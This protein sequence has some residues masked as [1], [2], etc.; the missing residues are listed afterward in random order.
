MEGVR[1]KLQDLHAEFLQLLG[2]DANRVGGVEFV[3]SV[4]RRSLAL[5][6]AYR[7][8]RPH[9]VLRAIGACLDAVE[10]VHVEGIHGDLEVL[11][12]LSCG[13]HSPVL[14][15][16]GGY[17]LPRLEAP[18]L[19]GKVWARILHVPWRHVHQVLLPNAVLQAHLW[20]HDFS[21]PRML[22]QRM[23]AQ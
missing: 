11:G 19:L 7:G 14:A 9:V 17:I 12:D 21:K 5:A 15:E 18:T 6:L 16:D 3:A 1:L 10:S 13:V 22:A 20:G 23:L 4:V 2:P 8:R